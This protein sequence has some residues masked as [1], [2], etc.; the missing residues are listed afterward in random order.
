MQSLAM[1]SWRVVTVSY[2]RSY[3]WSRSHLRRWLARSR[4]N[5]SCSQEKSMPVLLRIK[6]SSRKFTILRRNW[7]NSETLLEVRL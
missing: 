5:W 7:L 6:T 4:Q 2:P 3:H 1:T